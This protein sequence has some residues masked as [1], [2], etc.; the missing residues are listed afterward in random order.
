[1][2]IFILIL[3]T[4][5]VKNSSKIIEDAIFDVNENIRSLKTE[6]EYVLLE[7]TYLSSPKNLTQYQ[8]QYFEKNLIQADITKIREL[9][10]DNNKLFEKNL[11]KSLSN[12]E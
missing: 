3:F 5:W 9:T 8:I 11:I 4:S 7:Y 6:I 2:S 10:E 12:N 1:M